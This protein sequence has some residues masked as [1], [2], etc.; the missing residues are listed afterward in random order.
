MVCFSTRIEKWVR[1]R[2]KV[3]RRASLFLHPKPPVQS[4]QNHTVAYLCPAQR[5]GRAIQ[6]R[7]WCITEGCSHIWSPSPCPLLVPVGWIALENAFGL[8]CVIAAGD[9]SFFFFFYS[10]PV[11][12]RS[13]SNNTAIQ[14]HTHTISSH[15]GLYLKHIC[16]FN[17]CYL[18]FLQSTC[19]D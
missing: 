13:G 1:F 15:F 2:F 14:T 17:S 10:S 9:Y 11:S 4:L 16:T 7:S 18:C 8:V 12:K 3:Q 19:F 6:A 5:V